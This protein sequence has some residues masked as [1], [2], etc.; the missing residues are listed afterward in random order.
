MNAPYEDRDDSF[1]RF[2]GWVP[3]PASSF[4]MLGEAPSLRVPHRAHS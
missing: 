1:A 3:N 2:V 4:G